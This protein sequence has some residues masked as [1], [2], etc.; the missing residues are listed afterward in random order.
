[1]LLQ[2]SRVF[3]QSTLP[4]TPYSYSGPL[5][6][7]LKPALAPSC[8]QLLPWDI[9]FPPRLFQSLDCR[10]HGSLCCL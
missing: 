10:D 6:I 1:M 5:Y 9:H 4:I 8:G 7:A 2:N 3:V